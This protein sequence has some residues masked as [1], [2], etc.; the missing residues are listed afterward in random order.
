MTWRQLSD[1]AADGHEIGGHAV[2]HVKLTTVSSS[3]ARHQIADDRQ[4]L[5]A[6][7]FNATDFAYPFGAYNASVKAIVEGCGYSSARRSWVLCPIGQSP[8]S[9]DIWYPDVVE[10]IPPVDPYAMRTI[11]SL[12]AWNTLAE[13][14]SVVTRAESSSGGWVTLVFHHICDGCRGDD[15]YSVSPST[16]A[17]FLDWLDRRA[18]RGAHVLTVQDVISERVRGV[19]A[20]ADA[21][22]PA[23][24]A[25]NA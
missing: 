10:R 13:M 16:F 15:G 12:R 25:S 8:P 20:S 7:G 24:P 3:E 11:V 23:L 5:I 4:T 19:L 21:L 17:R 14:Q 22:R 2:D 6:H 18:D 1:L 9:C